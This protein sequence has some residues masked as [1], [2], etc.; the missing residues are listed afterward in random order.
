MPAD[1]TSWNGELRG[2]VTLPI[3]VRVVVVAL[4]GWEYD[5]HPDAER[6]LQGGLDRDDI[7]GAVA[8]G[9][10]PEGGPPEVEVAGVRTHRENGE[11]IGGV[12]PA[13][14]SGDGVCALGRFERDTYGGREVAV[15]IGKDRLGNG[16]VPTA[17]QIDRRVDGHRCIGREAG[18]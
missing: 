8:H 15:A 4:T 1:G 16:S 12:R 11:L 9:V 2:P 10:V 17:P 13:S 5:V 3:G 7:V 14:R 6:G 18:A